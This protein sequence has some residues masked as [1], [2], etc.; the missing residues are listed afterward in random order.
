MALCLA[1]GSLNCYGAFTK[2]P[3]ANGWRL[4]K[5]WSGAALA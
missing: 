4:R 2:I 5:S 1:G 3:D